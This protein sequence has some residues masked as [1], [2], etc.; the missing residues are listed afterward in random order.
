M[1]LH[2][3]SKDCVPQAN[4]KF[5]LA[6]DGTAYLGWQE[7]PMGAS[8][9][10][11]LARVLQQILQVPVRLQAASRTDAG[12]H[13]SG[14]V[15]NFTTARIPD[16]SLLT[17][18]LN[19]LLPKDLVILEAQLVDPQFHPTIDA[20]GKEYNYQVCSDRIQLPKNRLYSWH[21]PANLDLHAM[22]EA[23]QHLLG[24]HDFQAFSNIKK[25]ETYAHHICRLDRL[26][27]IQEPGKRWLFKIAGNRFLYKMVRNLVGTLVYVGCGKLKAD[28]MQAILASKRRPQ[29]GITAPA[30]GLS[31]HEVFYS[32]T[33]Q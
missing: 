10:G 33:P 13:A 20:L 6:Y 12:V 29:A 27:I 31:L 16:L 32:P 3:K 1:S 9:E 19:S 23:S 15:V 8:V 18:G 28:Q 4:I 25:K 26:D 7:T 2:V 24:T 21:Y 22:Q 5:K 17:Y 14:Q 11:V 30:H